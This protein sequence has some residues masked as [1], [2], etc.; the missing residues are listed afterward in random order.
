MHRLRQGEDT[1]QAH[2]TNTRLAKPEP[3]LLKSVTRDLLRPNLRIKRRLT[4]PDIRFSWVDHLGSLEDLPEGIEETEDCNADVGSEEA[5]QLIG[6][7]RSG[8]ED[9]ETVEE[10]DEGEVRKASPGNVG[11]PF[12]LEDHSATVDVL[13]NACRTEPGV[14]VGDGAPSEKRRDGGQVLEPPEDLVGTSA[15]THVC[16]Q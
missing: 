10:N 12:A 11:L 8:G 1:T 14:C 3:E 15:D 7:P 9:L 13:G 5:G 6:S 2:A 4:A 16:E